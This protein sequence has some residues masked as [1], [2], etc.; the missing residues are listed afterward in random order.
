MRA[1]E[2]AGR[3]VLHKSLEGSLR[4]AS[5]LRMPA[6]AERIGHMLQVRPVLSVISL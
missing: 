5:T 4:L 6:L 1:L 2:L 3:L